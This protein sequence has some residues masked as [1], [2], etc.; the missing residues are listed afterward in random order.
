MWHHLGWFA[1]P[2]VMVESA[3]HTA[4]WI[5]PRNSAPVILGALGVQEPDSSSCCVPS[6][7]TVPDP[8]QVDAQ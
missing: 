2:G 1:G 4:L 6:P 7:S 3:D 5:V 8:E